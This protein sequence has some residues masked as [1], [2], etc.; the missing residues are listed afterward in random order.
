MLRISLQ[1]FAQHDSAINEMSSKAIAR[2]TL[3]RFVSIRVNSW[4]AL[5]KL[6]PCRLSAVP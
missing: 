3:P 1:R 4:L 5:L 2:A 6:E